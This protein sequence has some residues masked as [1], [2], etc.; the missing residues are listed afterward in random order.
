MISGR[1]PA[2]AVAR[3]DLP[4]VEGFLLGDLLPQNAVHAASLPGPPQRCHPVRSE[5]RAGGA[6]PLLYEAGPPTRLE[7]RRFLILCRGKRGK[8][9]VLLCAH[10]RGRRSG[11]D[12]RS[13]RGW[14]CRASNAERAGPTRH[15]A[16]RSQ[17]RYCWRYGGRRSG[18]CEFGAAASPCGRRHPLPARPRLR[19]RRAAVGA[20]RRDRRSAD[21]C[22][23]RRAGAEI[24]AVAAAGRSSLLPPPPPARSSMVSAELKPCSTTSVEYFST[25]CWSVH[26]RVCSCAFEV[27][28]R[29]L[30]QILLGDLGEPFVEDHHAVPLGLLL[31]LAGRLVAPAFRWSRRSCSR[32]GGRPACAGPPGPCPDCRPE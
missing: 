26:L 19:H 7:V 11:R 32:P 14:L 6:G 9:K 18:R 28:L 13:E 22:P 17:W 23:A 1:G 29:A 16:R 20:E 30:L 2:A 8:G 15:L 3:A 10:P 31:A 24:L 4:G 25:P 5:L 12:R 21:G 27:N